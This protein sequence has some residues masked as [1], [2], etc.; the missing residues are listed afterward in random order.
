MCSLLLGVTTKLTGIITMVQ[1]MI[2]LC[3]FSQGRVNVWSL[4]LSLDNLIV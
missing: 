2:Y 1:G 3:D 4:V